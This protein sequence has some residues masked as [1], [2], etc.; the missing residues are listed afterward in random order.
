[1]E[2][3]RILFTGVGEYLTHS[4]MIHDLE[5]RLFIKLRRGGLSVGE[6]SDAIKRM[7]T[8]TADKKTLSPSE[9]MAFFP[10]KAAV[11]SQQSE[12]ASLLR[13]SP[14]VG[15]GGPVVFDSSAIAPVSFTN[16]TICGLLLSDITHSNASDLIHHR[17]LS[18][19][20]SCGLISSVAVRPIPGRDDDD[21]DG[22]VYFHVR[23]HDRSAD[24]EVDAETV[25]KEC[26]AYKS[27]ETKQIE[28]L[29]PE[30]ALES[31]L[32]I[33]RPLP[34]LSQTHKHQ[35]VLNSRQANAVGA[36]LGTP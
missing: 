31:A 35:D 29:G 9:F 6:I 15:A 16:T 7:A 1:V 34:L 18:N 26:I 2:A 33:A 8:T 28:A 27:V 32:S 11:S 4:D 30:A 22:K 21:A 13:I 23:Y 24:I 36:M 12:N 25:F 3:L 5:H 19:K 10:L 17:C 20:G 14:A